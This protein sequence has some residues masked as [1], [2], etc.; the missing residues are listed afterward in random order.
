VTHI[1]REAAETLP[2]LLQTSLT[3]LTM[4]LIAETTGHAARMTATV[5]GAVLILRA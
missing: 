3:I 1:R 5:V 4:D 2:Q